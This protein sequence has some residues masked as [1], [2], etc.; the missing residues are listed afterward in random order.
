MSTIVICENKGHIPVEHWSSIAKSTNWLLNYYSEGRTI[1]EY[2]ILGAAF[3]IVAMKNDARSRD[4]K[5]TGANIKTAK[6]SIWLLNYYSGVHT[7]PEYTH[8]GVVFLQRVLRTSPLGPGC[9]AGEEKCP[10]YCKL[11]AIN[12]RL[13]QGEEFAIPLQQFSGP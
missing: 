7:S 10:L 13:I 5:L 2:N 1:P 8:S 4:C 9:G 12:D 11:A 6:P 3:P